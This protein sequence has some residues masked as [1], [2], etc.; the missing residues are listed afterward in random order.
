[1]LEGE[2]HTA[3]QGET[4]ANTAAEAADCPHHIKFIMKD[5]KV[6]AMMGE[7]G[8][9]TCLVA[10]KFH[11]II[12]V[13]GKHDHHPDPEAQ[14]FKGRVCSVHAKTK[15]DAMKAVCALVLLASRLI[16]EET[17]QS[18]PGQSLAE[19]D[20]IY[21]I[22]PPSIQGSL[23]G[24]AGENQQRLKQVHK[25]KQLHLKERVDWE[26]TSTGE[27]LLLCKGKDTDF[28]KLIS[29]VLLLLGPEPSKYTST[30][31]KA[32]PNPHGKSVLASQ[33]AERHKKRQ[34]KNRKHVE[35]KK[36]RAARLAKKTL[37]RKIT[38]KQE[39]LVRSRGAGGV[40][41][42]AIAKQPRKQGKKGGGSG[43]AGGPH[44]EIP[45]KHHQKRKKKGNRGAA[46]GAHGAIKQRPRQTGQK[47]GGKDAAGASHGASRALL[48]SNVIGDKTVRRITAI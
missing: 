46:G 25:L 16:D 9:D 40:A 29:E 23:M 32:E 22:I 10:E 11:S 24:K 4:A 5:C 42:G 18:V 19:T 7:K 35:S 45:T 14:E 31:Q 38:R 37:N 34:V 33:A 36:E 12:Q 27:R 28:R 2:Q 48:L 30:C 3:A 6:G 21:I 13:S 41:H 26:A 47:G 20:G 15:D 17:G 8:L 1:M 43:A 39:R 44:G